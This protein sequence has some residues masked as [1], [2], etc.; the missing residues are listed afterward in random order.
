MPVKFH[1]RPIII[2]AEA[3]WWDWS[4]IGQ[5]RRKPW[6]IDTHIKW[7]AMQ[8]GGERC[9]IAAPTIQ[10]LQP[11]KG[12]YIYVSMDY[13][14]C[15]LII[16]ILVQAKILWLAA[17]S[18]PAAIINNDWPHSVTYLFRTIFIAIE[19]HDFDRENST[20]TSGTDGLGQHCGLCEKNNGSAYI[21]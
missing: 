17:N 3:L 6:A 16:L 20:T 9:Y 13:F 12:I 11:L 10:L 1:D 21:F 18:P 14:V 8:C 4:K 7:A 5:L 19:I 2:W 15:I